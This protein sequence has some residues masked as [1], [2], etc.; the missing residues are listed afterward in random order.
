MEIR[1]I[2]DPFDG[3]PVTVTIFEDG[4]ISYTHRVSHK[5]RHGKISN[6]YLCIPMEFLNEKSIQAAKAAEL[7]GLSRMRITQLCD[8]QTLNSDIIGSSLF[9]SYD[10]VMRYK[11]ENRKPGRKEK[12]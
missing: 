2:Y 9:V 4:T 3:L 10:D 5:V 1:E 12:K 11:R 7:L 8:A 6:G